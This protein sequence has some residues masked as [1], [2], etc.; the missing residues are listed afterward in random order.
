MTVLVEIEAEVT[1]AVRE[2]TPRARRRGP[3]VVSPPRSTTI[4]YDCAPRFTS[5]ITSTPRRAIHPS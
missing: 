4:V 3:T 2:P 5:T 1:R